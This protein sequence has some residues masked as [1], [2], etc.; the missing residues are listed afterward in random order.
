MERE[1]FLQRRRSGIGGSD[2]AAIIG[3]SPWRT[4]RDIYLDKKG[5]AKEPETEAMYWG[6][7][8]EDLVAREYSKR[9]GR[10]VQR[11][12]TQFRHPKYPFLLANLDRVVY[13]ENGKSPVVK[14]KLVTNRIL[15]CKTASQ[16]ASGEWGE[17]GGSQIPEHYLSQVQWYMGIT[18]AEFCDVAVLI[19]NRDFRVYEIRRDDSIID[20][21]FAEGINFWR[22][23]IETDTLPPARTLE[24]VENIHHGEAK[25]RKFADDSTIEA[26]KRYAALD[27]QAKAIKKEQEELKIK[28]CDAIG[29][30]VELVTPD[31]RKLCSWSAAKPV[32]KT[33]WRAVAEELNASDEII[34]AH[35]TQSMSARRFILAYQ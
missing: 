11:C 24:D 28:I 35:T 10:K 13:R 5:L 20:Y 17:N 9:T 32:N 30:A 27:E 22:K 4:P 1:E 26:V 12:N 14:G 8:L 29:D 3:I 7:T 6:A 19:G 33:D 21:L 34:T 15:E 2:I 25:A 18:G 23:Y 31:A 16:Y